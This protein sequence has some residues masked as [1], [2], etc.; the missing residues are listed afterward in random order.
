MK[1]REFAKTLALFPLIEVVF[2]SF[3]RDTPKKKSFIFPARKIP[4]VEP[5]DIDGKIYNQ[6]VGWKH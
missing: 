6:L 1:R 2:M 3:K 5:V 4:I